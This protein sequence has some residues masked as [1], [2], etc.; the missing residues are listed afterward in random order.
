MHA[1]RRSPRA[2]RRPRTRPVAG[3]HEPASG[4][5]PVGPTAS[6]PSWRPTG[7]ST[8]TATVEVTTDGTGRVSVTVSWFSGDTAGQPGAGDGA[9]LTFKR[10]GA[11]RYTLTVDHTFTGTGC[12]WTVQATTSPAAAGGS[13]SQQLLTR[14]CDLR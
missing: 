14:R 11:T 1:Q 4:R 2:A 9:P 8:A 7:P 6:H 13:V 10:S 5:P 12:C 3:S